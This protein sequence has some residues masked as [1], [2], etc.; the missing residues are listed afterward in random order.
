MD[1]SIRLEPSSCGFAMMLPQCSHITRKRGVYYYRRRLPRHLTREVTLSL[2]TR[3]FREAQWL[4]AKLDREF[5]KLMLSVKKYEKPEDIQRIAREYLKSRLEHDMEVRIGSPHVGVYSR[6]KE[7]GR[8]VADDLEWIE[9]E[10]LGARARLRER[11][12]EHERETIDYVMQN[13]GVPAEQRNALAH[14]LYQA[15]VEFWEAVI[16]RTKGNQYAKPPML[17]PLEPAQSNGVTAPEPAIGP[18]LSESCQASSITWRGTRNGAV[19]RW[20]RIRPAMQC[21]RNAAAIFP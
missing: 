4:A 2:R 3:S 15:D 18:L 12:Y 8:I 20:R 7:P 1:F 16:E 17:L 14:A 13:R 11:L 21:S 5:R 6:S 19:R 10:L 9:G